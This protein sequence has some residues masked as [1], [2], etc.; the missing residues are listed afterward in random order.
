V[1]MEADHLELYAL[2]ELPE[3]LCSAIEWGLKSCGDSGQFEESRL[4]LG[5][6][7]ALAVEPAYFGPEKRKSPRVA[8]DDPALLTVLKPEQSARLKIRI[9]DASKEGLKLLVPRE[10]MRGMI[11]QLHVHEFFILAEVRY[12]IPAGED[13]HAGVQIQDV[14]RVAG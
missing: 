7:T 2:E 10:L 8:T 6:W 4:T 3:D 1:H 5:Q 13:F 12:S 14:F 11:V 9:V